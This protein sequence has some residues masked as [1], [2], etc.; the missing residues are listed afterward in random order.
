LVE[1]EMKMIAITLRY[2]TG[3]VKDRIVCAE[4]LKH[5]RRFPQVKAVENPTEIETDEPCQSMR[6]G[7]W[8]K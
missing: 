8:K 7:K 1:E 3:T 6:H 5:I 2:I 4:C